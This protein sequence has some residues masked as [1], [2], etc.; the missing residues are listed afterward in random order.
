MEVGMISCIALFTEFP[1]VV[2]FLR[3]NL[4]P[5][6]VTLGIAFFVAVALLC[7]GPTVGKDNKNVL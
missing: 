2:S 1:G 4:M 7:N 5:L 6:L 3:E